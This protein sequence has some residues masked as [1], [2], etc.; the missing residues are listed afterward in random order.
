MTLVSQC[1]VVL[2]VAAV[3]CR[4]QALANAADDAR[5]GEAPTG[6]DSST[7]A[8]PPQFSSCVGL[9]TACGSSAA[10]SCC[11]SPL[12]SGGTYYRS[13]DQA[14]DSS[15]G[16]MGYPARLSAFRLD[17]Y[18]VTVGRF[19]AFVNAGMGTQA[20]PPLTGAGA[21][22]AISGS[23]WD[24]SWNPSLPTTKT[25]L[26]TAVKCDAPFGT[27]TDAPGGN[28]N[29][30]MNCITWFEAMAFC[31]WDGG[32]LPTEAEWNYAAAGGDLQLAYPWSNPAGSLTLDAIHASY[33]DGTNCVGDGMGG[34]AVTDL[35]PV[36]TKP[37]GD[38]R[39]GQSDLAGNVWE[40][41]L[42][43]YSANYLTPCT[44][45]AN[46]AAAP[47]RVFRG[48]SFDNVAFTLRAGYRIYGT[49][50]SRNGSVG[51]RCARTP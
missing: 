21:R 8:A 16:T 7:D 10:D 44:D 19:R 9:A 34:C 14:G 32:F 39:W 49:P 27:W 6:F 36:G 11:T 24:A 28:E 23:G 43:R 47:D 45:C 31:A 20:S 13:Y 22:T 41:T 12:V 38:S 17:K 51:V 1:C 15:S 37:A 40:W 50:V 26:M 2:V 35:V 46:T 30:P 48:G 29:R 5:E 3:G 18:E 42:D 33:N 25:A 4:Y